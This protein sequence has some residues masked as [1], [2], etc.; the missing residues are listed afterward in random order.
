MS[1]VLSNE[2]ANQSIQHIQGIVNGGFTDQITALDDQGRILSDPNV[3]DG[4]LAVTLRA[5]TWPETKD[6]LDNTRSEL[7][8][9]RNQ[10]QKISQGIITA[11]GGA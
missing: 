11:G 10:L 1:R 7:E 5:S 4:P 8:E 6:A 2:Q 3:W 9:L